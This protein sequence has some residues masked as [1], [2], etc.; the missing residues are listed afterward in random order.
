MAEK[1]TGLQ[2]AKFQLRD[3]PGLMDTPIGTFT[4]TRAIELIHYEKGNDPVFRLEE[5]HHE[6]L[7]TVAYFHDEVIRELATRLAE[8]RRD[9]ESL[10]RAEV[11]PVPDTFILRP[12][13]RDQWQFE[14]RKIE[15]ARFR[16]IEDE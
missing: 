9:L 15:R 11:S 2:K 8:A 4:A 13:R 12:I 3:Y 14:I 16:F 1:S 10:R 7:D 6:D 5:E